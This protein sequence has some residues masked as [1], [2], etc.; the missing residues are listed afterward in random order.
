MN[1]KKFYNIIDF[2]SSKIRLSIYD[3]NSNE[4]YSETILKNNK[5]ISNGRCKE[6][7]DLIKRTEKKISYLIEDVI[8][9][10]DSSKLFSIDISLSRKLDT[11]DS[12]FKTFN[13]I[14]L[15]AK[16]I[17]NS[18]YNNFDIV[19]ITY[20]KYIINEK[21]YYEYFI[22]DKKIDNLKIDFKLI[23]F[24]KNL[25][26]SIENIFNNINIKI[27]KIYSSSYVK[28]YYYL[29]K[30]NQKKT[31]FLEIG[32]DRSTFFIYENDRLR[33]VQSIPIGGHHITNDISKVF[34]IS[35]SESEIIK[36]A[37]NKSETE[38][39]Y[40][41]NVLLNNFSFKDIMDKKISINLLIKVIL[42]RIQEILDFNFK[43]TKI[44]AL[45]LDLKDTNLF[46]MGDG[47][48]LFNNNSFHLED[49][50]NFNSINFYSETD[51][52]ICK[53]GLVFYH[54]DLDLRKINKKKQGIFERFF[55]FFGK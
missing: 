17:I 55:N 47:S 16:H 1:K 44:D 51:N 5:S 37:F 19:H 27:I 40:N 49:K 34:K 42:Y 52:G 41:K 48:K 36:K 32:Y 15:E 23:C 11:K 18:Y 50:F 13:T 10:V 6:L 45:K 30:L 35:Y 39:S 7:E 14:A 21:I 8:I 53:A 12:F 22:D 2:G 26:S 9:L 33:F 24:P 4:N 31:S 43:K 28:T 25:I 54:K 20:E 3:N 29:K 46:L 38:F